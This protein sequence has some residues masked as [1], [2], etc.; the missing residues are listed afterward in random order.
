MICRHCLGVGKNSASR[1]GSQLLGVVTE[2]ADGRCLCLRCF[3]VPSSPSEDEA[4]NAPSFAPPIRVTPSS[5]AHGA[6][7]GRRN[8]ESHQ[9]SS[10]LPEHHEVRAGAEEPEEPEGEDVHRDRLEEHCVRLRPQ[11]HVGQPGGRLRRQSGNAKH[12]G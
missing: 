9:S 8:E 7:R 4:A 11:L 1:P 5:V 2:V 10:L 12:S 3:V 6:A